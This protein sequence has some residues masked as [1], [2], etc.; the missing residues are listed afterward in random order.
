MTSIFARPTEDGLLV[1]EL[2]VCDNCY[3]I[4]G[5]TY[6]VYGPLLNGLTSVF[7]EGIPTYPSASR[8]WEIV[9]Q[10]QVTKIYTSPTA[11]R[12]LMGFGDELVRQ[13]DR[14][15]L[16]I[17][18][19]VGEPINPGA[20]LWLYEVVGNRSAA[21]VDTYWQT[22][23][24]GHVIA[25]LPGAVPTK[26]GSAT[27]PFPGVRPVIVDNDGNI[28]EGPGEG[29]L[30]FDAPW[31][32]ISRT[33]LFDH[34]RYEKTYYKS[35]PGY[36]FTGDGARRDEDGYF[37]ITGR[38]DDLMN[39]S[40]HLLSTAEIE[41]ALAAHEDVIESAVVA[42]EHPIKG[43]SPYAFVVMRKVGLAY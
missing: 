10:H 18:G 17:I 35:F 42:I 7:F 36:Y 25:P 6:G 21:I 40:G 5:H 3:S 28:I 12:C 11:I 37:W 39:V 43:H 2:R 16:K 34:G 32:G 33:V 1:I 26:P 8:L 15:S 38:V 20:W 29:N 9:E 22:E 13:H 31:P 30:C 27:L 4:L 19:T 23:T 24:G 41:S 14:S